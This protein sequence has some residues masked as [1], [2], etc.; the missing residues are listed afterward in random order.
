MQPYLYLVSDRDFWETSRGCN[1]RPHT[2]THTHVDTP[3][4]VRPHDPVTETHTSDS[5]LLCAFFLSFSPS[6]GVRDLQ[7][8]N[9]RRRSRLECNEVQ[10]SGCWPRGCGSVVGIAVCGNR[11]TR[12]HGM[13]IRGSVTHGYVAEKVGAKRNSW[14]V[15]ICN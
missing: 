11:W 4:C 2:Q 6:H 3:V 12:V 5:L 15:E 1:V 9:P 10:R 14:D 8:V 13:W 7:I